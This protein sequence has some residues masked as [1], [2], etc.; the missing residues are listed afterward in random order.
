MRALNSAVTAGLILTAVA[1]DGCAI[2]HKKS[3]PVPMASPASPQT[4]AATP[5]PN[6]PKKTLWYYL[7]PFTWASSVGKLLPHKAKPPAAQAPQLIGTIKMVNKEDKFVL[8]DGASFQGTAPGDALVCITNQKETANLRMSTLK[9]PPFLIADIT[10]GNP[11]PGDK[12]FK[13]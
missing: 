2:F 1:L 3:Q 10:N 13:P 9:N 11:S 6:Q 7:S 5:A 8:I 4:M 12:V